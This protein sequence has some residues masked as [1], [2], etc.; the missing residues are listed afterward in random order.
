MKSLLKNLVGILAGLL[1]AATAAY[2]ISGGPVYQGNTNVV[3][4]YAGVMTAVASPTPTPTATPDVSPS[5][6][7]TATPDSNDTH[8]SLGVFSI[9]VPQ[10]GLASGAFVMFTQGRVFNGSIQGVADPNNASLKGVLTAR[11]DFTKSNADGTNPHNVTA[12]VDG[13]MK[14]K[15]VNPSQPSAAVTGIRLRG[16]ATLFTNE[17]QVRDNNTPIVT[18]TLTLKVRGYKQS[19]TATTPTIVSP[20]SSVPPPAT[21]TPTAT[22]TTTPTVSPTATP[23]P[24]ETPTP[25]PTETPTPTPTPTP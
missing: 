17:G 2:A 18:Q 19:N 23:T 1:F 8:N 22:A 16:H 3:G 12:T 6:T 14:T 7:P 24:T 11:F 25:T 20:G 10:T 4:T 9:G 5:S 21:A 15:I 13:N